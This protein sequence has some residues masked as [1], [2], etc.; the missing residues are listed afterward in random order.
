MPSTATLKKFQINT[1]TIKYTIINRVYTTLIKKFKKITRGSSSKMLVIPSPSASRNRRCKAK[2]TT[3]TKG[4]GEK[5]QKKIKNDRGYI[6]A[7][8]DGSVSPRCHIRA[9]RF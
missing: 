2:P 6:D 3:S 4:K 8:A 7:N 1:Y 9:N 5:E